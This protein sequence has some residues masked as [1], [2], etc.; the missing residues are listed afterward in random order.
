MMTEERRIFLLFYISRT[1]PRSSIFNN[2]ALLETLSETNI[3]FIISLIT[4]H[5]PPRN[6]RFIAMSP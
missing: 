6:H 3:S 5:R 2:V 4:L 1:W